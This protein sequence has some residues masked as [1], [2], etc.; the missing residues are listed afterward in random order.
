MCIQAIVQLQFTE[1]DEVD[2]IKITCNI[3]IFHMSEVV[4]LHAPLMRSSVHSGHP[5]DTQLHTIEH[6]QVAFVCMQSMSKV[7]Q[8]SV[9]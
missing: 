9:T 6:H 2:S 3:A 4:S 7:L 8:G 5:A 1:P